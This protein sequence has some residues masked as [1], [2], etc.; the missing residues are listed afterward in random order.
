VSNFILALRPS[1]ERS[2]LMFKISSPYL[3]V[4]F[5]AMALDVLLT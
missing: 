4:L 1:R 2:W 3:F 5:L